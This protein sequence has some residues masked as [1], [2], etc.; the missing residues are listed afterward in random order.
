[1]VDLSKP[2]VW[3]TRGNFNECD[4][5]QF[6]AECF[7]TDWQVVTRESDPNVIDHIVFAKEFYIG[8][9]L[10]KREAHVLKPNGCESEASTNNN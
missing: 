2:V 8:G 6:G 5:D 4:L 7:K 9:E 3:T 1:M 10:V